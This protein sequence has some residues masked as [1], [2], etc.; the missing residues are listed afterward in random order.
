MILHRLRMYVGKIIQIAMGRRDGFIGTGESA[1]LLNS[2][3]ICSAAEKA[4]VAIREFPQQYF[5]FSHGEKTCYSTSSDF[6]FENLLAYKMCGNKLVTATILSENGLP[7]PWFRGYSID[8]YEQAL[9]DFVA[10]D[11]VVVVKP[12][13]GTSSGDGISVGVSSR[14]AF[15]SAFAKTL[16]YS[17]SVLV[18]EFVE[19]ENYRFTV[20][21]GK[22]LTVIRRLPAYVVGNGTATIRSLIR[23]KNR[24]LADLKAETKLLKPI[25]IDAD[26]A[27][28]LKRQGIKLGSVP[29]AGQN[30]QLRQVANADQGGEICDVTDKCHSDYI[31]MAA[32]AASLMGTS[33]AGTDLI[34]QDISAP[35]EE[36]RAVINEVNTT[37]ALYIVREPAADGSIDVRVGEEILN[38]ALNIND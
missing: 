4:G 26:V 25:T 13:F 9:Q 2:R 18:E 24:G 10:L 23:E 19:G 3:I 16:A 17:N 1:A 27:R 28:N 29:E 22:V 38:F 20:L 31:V 7:V 21:G 8:E 14:S 5:A 11:R 6:S 30:I 15:A 36:G 12:C 35:Y 34:A 32:K 37:P 33:L